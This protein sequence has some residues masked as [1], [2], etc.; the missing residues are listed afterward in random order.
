MQS[1][2]FTA[3]G[4]WVCPQSVSAVFVQG[5]GGGG[6]GGGGDTGLPGRSLRRRRGSQRSLGLCADARRTRHVL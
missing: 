4:V 1:Q 2:E 6:G 5:Q 3:N